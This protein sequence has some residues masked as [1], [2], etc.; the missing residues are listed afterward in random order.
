MQIKE[1]KR[2]LS[3]WENTWV[4]RT[5]HERGMTLQHLWLLGVSIKGFRVLAAGLAFN[6]VDAPR[7]SSEGCGVVILRSSFACPRPILRHLLPS[8]NSSWEWRFLPRTLM[9]PDSTEAAPA[10]PW[11]L[12]QKR[13]LPVSK[14]CGKRS[15]IFS[16]ISCDRAFGYSGI[17]YQSTL[18]SPLSSTPP[19]PFPPQH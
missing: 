5:S 4:E 3:T 6:P 11:L 15:L 1:W 14:H 17:L 2:K 16:Q 19:F 13:R 9:P 8:T 18:S 12:L 7:T 10:P